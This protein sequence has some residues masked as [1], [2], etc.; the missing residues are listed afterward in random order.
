MT[1]DDERLRALEALL[2]EMRPT[3]RLPEGRTRDSYMGAL[4]A[5]ETLGLE[6]TQL[7]SGQHIIFAPDK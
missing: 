3:S 7:E 2:D 4:A 6:W 1:L 5:I